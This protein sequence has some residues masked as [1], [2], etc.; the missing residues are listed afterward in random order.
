MQNIAD[1]WDNAREKWN[2]IDGATVSD[3]RTLEA[4]VVIIGTGAGGGTSAEI[5]ANAGLRVLLVE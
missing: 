2:L 1:P 5:L 4:D 3:D